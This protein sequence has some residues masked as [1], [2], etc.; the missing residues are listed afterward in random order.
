MNKTALI[1]GGN[2]GIGF[3]TAR[4]LG[5]LGYTVFLGARSSNKGQMAVTKLRN[6]NVD[7]RFINIDCSSPESFTG[8][9]KEFSAFSTDLNVL[10]NNAAILLDKADIK[11]VTPSMMRETFEINVTGPLLIINAFLPFMKKGARIINV[12]SGAGS[13]NDMGNYAPAYS[14]S[15]A[16]LNAVTRQ[17]SAVLKHQGI[18]VNS[19][20]PGWVRTDMGG[21][22]APRDVKAGAEG[23][24]W[25]AD[26]ADPQ[27]TGK[28]FRDGKEIRW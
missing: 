8:A 10:I 25:L 5:K 18:A 12:S 20:C 3:E 15:K 23:I 28:F 1:T 7:A 26:K 24:V 22:S 11:D 9:A 6:E 21:L 17:F 4:Q 13:L 19:V 14:I 27:I 16:A 2:R